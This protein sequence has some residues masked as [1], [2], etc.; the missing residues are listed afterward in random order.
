VAKAQAGDYRE[1][2]LFALKQSLASFRYYQRLIAEVDT[3]IA[4][5][6][7]A[8]EKSPVAEVKPPGPDEEEP[9]PTQTL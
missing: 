7:Q 2:H 1:Q 6:L 5:R 9:L 4:S 3:E 8:V